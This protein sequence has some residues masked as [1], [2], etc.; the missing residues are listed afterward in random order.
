MSSALRLQS[1][2]EIL[3][4]LLS[5]PPPLVFFLSL[6][7]SLK[8]NELKKKKISAVLQSLNWH[9]GRLGGSVS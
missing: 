4:L 3:S 7:L 6:S 9:E 2:L 5:D 8:I 1:L